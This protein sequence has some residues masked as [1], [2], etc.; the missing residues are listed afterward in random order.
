MHL[1]ILA[2]EATPKGLWYPTILGVL[3]VIAAVGLFCGSIYLLLA[4]L[5][6]RATRVLEWWLSPHLRGAPPHG[7]KLPVPQL[8]QIH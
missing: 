5:L 1:L 2:Q 8:E 4:F 6:T 7:G 3:V